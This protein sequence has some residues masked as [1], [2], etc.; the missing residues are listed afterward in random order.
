MYQ[1]DTK[2][3]IDK[4]WLVDFV[5]HWFDEYQSES[6]YQ[7]VFSYLPRKGKFLKKMKT[8]KLVS[9]SSKVEKN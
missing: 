7:T 1:R 5:C 2:W 3:H 6:V 8:H 4:L 9:F